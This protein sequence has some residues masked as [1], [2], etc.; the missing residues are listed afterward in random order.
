MHTAYFDARATTPERHGAAMHNETGARGTVVVGLCTTIG[1]V[2]PPREL[3]AGPFVAAK[4]TAV[5]RAGFLEQPTFLKFGGRPNLLASNNDGQG[6][7][8]RTPQVHGSRGPR[9]RAK[10][11][12]YSGREFFASFLAET[13]NLHVTDV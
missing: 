6:A 7:A 5:S 9:Y 10:G 11:V 12:C 2:S 1:S 3:H 4:T 8:R 13:R